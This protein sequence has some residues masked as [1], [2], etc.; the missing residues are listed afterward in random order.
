MAVV[1]MRVELT[2]DELVGRAASFLGLVAA[3]IA[4]HSPE[5]AGVAIV[6]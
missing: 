2:L 4:P 6:G 5:S 1:S 3:A